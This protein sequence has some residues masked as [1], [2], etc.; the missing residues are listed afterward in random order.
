MNLD[1]LLQ[2]LEFH[3]V[4]EYHQNYLNTENGILLLYNSS[5]YSDRD[6][7]IKEGTFVSEA[8]EIL[9]NN[10]I[11]PIYHLPL[12]D[13][14]IAKTKIEGSRLSIEQIYSVLKLLEISR[15]LINFLKNKDNCD[16][17]KE[18]FAHKLY[19]NKNLE[20]EIRSI[21]TETGEIND[22]ASTKLREIRNEIREKNFILQK[23][24]NRI[25]KELKD[26][27]Y[28]QGDYVTLNEGRVVLPVKAEHKRHVKGF[29]HSES[30]TGQTVYIEPAET[31]ELNN[32]ILSLSF[33][34]KRE[35]D[36]ILTVI[37]KKLSEISLELKEVLYVIAKLDLIFAKA[38]Y[39]LEINGS[40]PTIDNEKPFELINA[41]HPILLKKFGIEKTI[42]LNF[43]IKDNIV[44]LITGPNAGGK[45]IVL[46][47][48]GLNLLLVYSGFHIPIHPDSN[49][50]LF[51]NI[52]IDIGDEQSIE[53][54]LSTF[55]SHLSNYKEILDNATKDSFIL[56]DEIGTGTDP[57]EGGAIAAAILNTLKNRGTK[58]L[59]TTHLGKLKIMAN[60]TEGFQ[61]A[62]MEYDLQ[63]LV[64]TYRFRQGI[65]GSSYAFEVAERIGFS[66]EFIAESKTYLDNSKTN[67]EKFLVELEEKTRVLNQKLKSVEI[68]N[69]KLKGLTELYQQK[70]NKLE[71]DKKEII[72]SAKT[73]ANLILQKVNSQIEKTIKSIKESAADKQVIKER[74]AEIEK[75]KENLKISEDKFEK[76]EL[77]FETGDYV[78]IKNTDSI[79]IIESILDN[80]NII[81]LVGSLKMK[82]KVDDIEISSKNAYKIEQK[83]TLKVSPNY[84]NYTLDI[85]GERAL[86]VRN[87]VNKFL[88]Q[89][90]AAGLD[91]VEIL[92]GK[93]TGALKKVVWEILK[94]HEGVNKF[95]FASIESGGEGITIVE[96]K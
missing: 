87:I 78:K 58:T 13:E 75:L 12:L 36:R 85:R 77:N 96:L 49:F 50:H 35:I 93:G 54:S 67:I 51:D 9:I 41:R 61:N 63:N 22:N 64:P 37:T 82:V 69:T 17:L 15:N 6:T 94:E 23:V 59:A 4:L 27:S 62:S 52:M 79:G 71:K 14:V 76:I 31:L 26:I 86:D 10:D 88:D 95:Y 43:S 48:L 28:V 20:N 73:E 7:I 60:D 3:K 80:K 19:S 46:K 53:S 21:F 47:T 8:K 24:I 5:P 40:F 30:A 39:S 1:N 56:L 89:S 84:A 70:I 74:R 33:A 68:E 57:E 45:T 65:P 18:E 72:N 90:Y 32:E 66:K 55:S 44:T 91:R 92:H 81:V 42:P 34:E 83:N 2:R 29:I 25:L 38:R 16:K 11:P